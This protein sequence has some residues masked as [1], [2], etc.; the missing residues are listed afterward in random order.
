MSTSFQD[1]AA[2]S[3][4]T[5]KPQESQASEAL[6]MPPALAAGSRLN[7]GPPESKER[8]EQGRFAEG[9]RGGPGNPFA[10]KVA[11]IRQA[12]FSAVSD[13]DLKGIVAAIIAEAKKGNVQAAKL[14]LSYLLGKPAAAVNPDRLD[15]E[16]WK[17]YQDTSKMLDEMPYQMS[18]VTPEFPLDMV[19]EMR[20]IFTGIRSSQLSNFF[21]TGDWTSLG[22]PEENEAY[23]MRWGEPK[24]R[25]GKVKQAHAKPNHTKAG[26]AKAGKGKPS[27]NGFCKPNGL[28]EAVGAGVGM[29]LA[30]SDI[31]V[32]NRIS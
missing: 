16:E 31:S 9:N 24:S 7:G 27:P 14:L 1:K 20:P 23:R 5:A 6:Q 26:N 4:K 10:R 18:R 22:T 32:V 12:F 19:R 30:N 29:P 25:L 13:E 11:A 3:P 2:S 21:I 15:I 17:G 8:D 28:R